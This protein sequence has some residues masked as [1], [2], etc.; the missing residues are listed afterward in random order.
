M[1]GSEG[2]LLGLLSCSIDTVVKVAYL[3]GVCQACSQSVYAWRARFAFFV[4]A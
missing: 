2:L 4:V 3:L 1:A